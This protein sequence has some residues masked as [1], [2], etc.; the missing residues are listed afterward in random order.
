[1]IQ[2]AVVILNWNGAFLLRQFL[3]DVVNYSVGM[4]H[5]WVI[6]NGSDDESLKVL[7]E[8]FP[9]VHVVQLEKNLGFAAGYNRGLRDIKADVY[10]LLNSDVSVSRDWL[11]PVLNLFD[12]NP[13]MAACQP[14]ILDWKQPNRFE[15]AG[16]AGG[17]M[18]KDGFM[19]CAGRIFNSFEE[20]N[21]QYSENREVFWASGACLF[22]R[23]DAFWEV[24]GLDEDFYAHMEEIDLCYRLKNRGYSVMVCG[25]SR[26]WHVGGA[27][28][29]MQHPFKLYLNFRNSLFLL[30]KNYREGWLFPLLLRRMILDGIAAVRFLTE[31]KPAFFWSVF[32]AHVQFYLM[33]PRMLAKRKKMPSLQPNSTGLYMGSIVRDFF[34]VGK[35]TFG[36][37]DRNKFVNPKP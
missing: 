21:G 19:F 20:D 32:R 18:D 16:A 35:K 30:T 14:L 8:E 2:T 33:L 27:S 23:T 10:V 7:S 12:L 13:K 3:P 31:G 1:V 22:V 37:L 34:F 17:Y 26:V 15:H 6:D 24:G 11:S 29:H 5:V 4:A 25:A 28:L 36:E 9:S